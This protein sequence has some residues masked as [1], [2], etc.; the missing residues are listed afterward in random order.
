MRTQDF[1]DI[2]VTNIVNLSGVGRATF[3]RLFDDKS[4][5]VLYQM[6]LVFTELIERTGPYSDSTAMVEALFELCF[7]RKEFFLS[8][9][10]ANLYGEF[11]IRLANI[12]SEKLSF[13]K[14]KYDLDDRSWQ[15]FIQVRTAMLLAALRVAITQFSD[16]NPPEVLETL[17]KLFGKQPAFFH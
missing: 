11:Q 3:Y 12:L 17:N 4:D 2:T 16:D 6:E 5:V 1:N 9:I 15:Y 8:L 10:K 13:V 7:G 14:D